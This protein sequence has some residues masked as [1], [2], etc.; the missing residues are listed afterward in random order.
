M[1]AYLHRNLF[2]YFCS[3]HVSN[4]TAPEIVKMPYPNLGI[5]ASLFPDLFE[6]L[7]P[8]TGLQC[9]MRFKLS[10]CERLQ[11]AANARQ[12]VACGLHWSWKYSRGLSVV[13]RVLYAT[14]R[15]SLPRACDDYAATGSTDV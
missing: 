9:P 13:A 5:F 1:A 14:L 7:N 10:H 4:R 3:H 11:S 15:K 6:L 12:G 8:F 2:G